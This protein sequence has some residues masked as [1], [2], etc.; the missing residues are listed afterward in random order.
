MIELQA[1]FNSDRIKVRD[2][3]GKI[4]ERN[5]IFRNGII[6]FAV[7]DALGAPAEF[8][9]RWMRDMDPVRE[10]RSGGIFD[11]PKGGWTDDTSMT[12]AALV[13][14]KSGFDPKD[15]MESIPGRTRRLASGNRF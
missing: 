2:Y 12:V 3:D 7:G 11:V 13:S 15:M 8:G 5:R 14:L 1:R 6:G 9:K 10:M 4:L